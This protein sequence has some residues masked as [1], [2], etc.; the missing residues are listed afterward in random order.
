MP[1]RRTIL[2][3]TTLL[4][5]L[6]TAPAFAAAAILSDQPMLTVEP[7]VHVGNISA[8]GLSAAAGLIATASQDKTLRLW[9][10]ASGEL[11]RTIH[12]PRG[13]GN[14]G[15]AYAAAISPDGATIAVGGWTG[16]EENT[17]SVYLFDP[18]GRMIRALEGLPENV[19]RLAFSRDGELLA[20]G[21]SG[22]HGVRVHARREG[23]DR[24]WSD[25]GYSDDCYGLDFAADGRLA[26]SSRDGHVRLHAPD[27]ARIGDARV[28]GPI[29]V[30]FSPDGT[31]LAVG[32]HAPR[33]ALLDGATLAPLPGP[34]TADLAG[35]SLSE[36]AWS[37]DGATLY[38]GGSF[39]SDESFSYPV[40]AWPDRGL[41]DATIV[42]GAQDTVRAILPLASGGLVVAS[43]DPRLAATDPDGATLWEVLPRQIDA[44][45]QYYDFALSDDGSTVDFAF[46]PLMG[47]LAR[48]SVGDPAL[49]TP[50]KGDG[51]TAPPDR[52]DPGV[53]YDDPTAPTFDGVALAMDERERALSHAL[54]PDGA[55]LVLGSD[56]HLRA[57]TSTGEPLW[58]RPA[59]APGLGDRDHPRRTPRRLRARGRHDPLAPDGGRRRDP[60][61]VPVLGRGR[62]GGLD[63]RRLLRRLAR[64]QGQAPLAGERG[65]RRGGAGRSRRGR[66]KSG[67]H[68]PRARRAR[69]RRARDRG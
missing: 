28:D 16:S 44:R 27:G 65:R 11:K 9:S 8:A 42:D 62:L 52:G 68:R 10:A 46:D 45:F 7:G 67:D 66:G 34:D 51:L 63:A 24:I 40:M 59:A 48:W 39:F 3:L 22:G 21:L 47:R 57:F 30:A 41:G 15:K 29:G 50:G 61:A 58:R 32:T 43:G 54:S 49:T 2:F 14:W 1:G 64:R 60:R 13:P 19:L 12:L 5:L 31:I 17:R 38:A 56:W 26:S 6:A 69:H 33:V 37:S 53:L 25:A 18:S 55:R 35:G 20:V 36:V 4:G 23:W